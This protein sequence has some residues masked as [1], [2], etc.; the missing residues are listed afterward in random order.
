MAGHRLL[1]E[2]VDLRGSA[3]SPDFFGNAVEGVRISPGQKDARAF[4]RKR[5]RDRG[6]DS[7]CGTVD[8]GVLVFPA[9]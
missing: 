2:R 5:T 3:G 8:D 7:S 9:T 4:A 6:A 1:V